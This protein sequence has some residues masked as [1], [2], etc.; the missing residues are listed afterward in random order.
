MRTWH[1]KQ[2]AFGYPHF[3]FFLVIS[4][5]YHESSLCSHIKPPYNHHIM[6]Y[7]YVYNHHKCHVIRTYGFLWTYD[8]SKSIAWSP[9]S[10]LK[11]LKMTI[12]T[13]IH[14]PISP[15]SN[16]RAG[17]WA[18]APR[19]FCGCGICEEPHSIRKW[20]QG[21]GK[22]DLHGGFLSHRMS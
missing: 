3:Q 10:H 13:Q 18:R 22:M 12:Y 5:G 17:S 14:S 7:I 21:G 20:P 16:P 6:K 1:D 9:F 15:A 8:T 11:Y 2:L 19:A 4:M